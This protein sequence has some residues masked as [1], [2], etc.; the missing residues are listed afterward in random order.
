MRLDTPEAALLR[1]RIVGLVTE[2]LVEH[3]REVREGREWEEMLLEAI[4]RGGKFEGGM[5]RFWT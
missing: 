5:G 4:D 2:T 1:E 3:R